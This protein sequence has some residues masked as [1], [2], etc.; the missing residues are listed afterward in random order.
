L[1]GCGPYLL[2]TAKPGLPDM[3]EPS[4][5]PPGKVLSAWAEGAAALLALTGLIG[6]W[7]GAVRP[8]GS[9]TPQ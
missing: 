9:G 8:A 3:Y 2:K 7:P 4:W 1:T 5:G 6:R